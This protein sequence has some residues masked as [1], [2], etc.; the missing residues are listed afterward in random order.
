MS[1]NAALQQ[2]K[3]LFGA[4]KAGHAGTLDPL[5][6]GLLPCCSAR[7]PSS[8]GRCSMRDKDYLADAP[9]RR[10]PR[11]PA[12]PRARSLERSRVRRRRERRSRGP[13][14]LPRRDRADAADV[15]G[16]Q[17]RR[18]A[19]LRARARAARK[20]SA[21]PRRVDDRTSSSCWSVPATL[22]A[23]CA[24]AAARAPTS[25]S[26][27]RTSARRWAAART[28]RRCGAPRPA[29][30]G[31]SRRSRLEALAAL[32]PAQR[33][34]RLLPLAALLAGPAARGARRRGRGARFA[35]GQALPIA[36]LADGPVRRLRP[37]RRGARP[38]ARRRRRGA[39]ARSG[40]A[41]SD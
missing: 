30:S 6:T 11:P 24:S 16:A 13:G 27:P 9:A 34:A 12:T 36:G 17:A 38:G 7:R 41:A 28:S 29:A 35:Q 15:F 40:S 18:R 2:A 5:A 32:T 20:S 22:H 21:Q 19:A 25:A 37:G 1:S 23:S 26:W 39:A 10:R 33:G 14:A 3:R 31:S 4:Q 8:P